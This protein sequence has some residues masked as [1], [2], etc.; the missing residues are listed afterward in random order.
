MEEP[1]EKTHQS[2]FHLN[3]RRTYSGEQ[4]HVDENV[5]MPGQD[6]LHYRTF[7]GFFFKNLESNS[8]GSRPVA[9]TVSSVKYSWN[10][11]HI[12][13]MWVLNQHKCNCNRNSLAALDE[14]CESAGDIN[15]I[16]FLKTWM[17]SQTPIAPKIQLINI[18]M[19]L[20]ERI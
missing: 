18:C 3:I 11:N 5:D 8:K 16:F 14:R 6:R 17:P 20:F 10:L 2:S 15:G 4:C 12:W 9:S 13:S 19:M 1:G 7:F